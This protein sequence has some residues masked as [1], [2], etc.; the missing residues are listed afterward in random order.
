MRNK[1][2]QKFILSFYVMFSVLV[3][4]LLAGGIAVDPTRAQQTK[5]DQA[6]NGVPMIN[7]NAPDQRGLSHSYFSDYN[8]GK[9]GLILNNSNKEFERSQLGGTVYGNPNLVGRKEAETILTEVTGI[10]R[11]V[12]AGYTEILGKKADYILANPNGIYLNG[13]GFINTKNVTLTTGRPIKDA[14]GELK[15]YDVDDGTIVVGAQGVD[16]KNINKTEIIS[17]TAELNGA[18]YGGE[19]VNVVLGRN[20]YE[21]KSKK[22]TA[23]KENGKAKPKVA[24]DAKSLGSM[25]AGRVYLTSTEKGVGV[26]SQSSLYADTG[27]LTIDV[28]GDLVLK[29]AQAKGNASLKAQKVKVQEKLIAEKSV[30]V[31]GKDIVN[32][33]TIAANQNVSVKSQTIKNTGKIQGKNIA[34]E[35]EQK[36]ENSGVI[37]STEKTYITTENLANSGNLLGQNVAIENKETLVNTGLLAADQQVS[38]QS[39]TIEN[40]GNIE[41]NSIL[42]QNEAKLTNTGRLLA[43]ESIRLQDSDLENQGLIAANQITLENQN[44]ATNHGE[45]KAKDTLTLKSQDFIN[46]HKIQAATLVIENQ[47]DLINQGSILAKSAK[48]TTKK[49][50]N[51]GTLYGE[52]TLDIEAKTLVNATAGILAADQ[53]QVKSAVVNDGTILGKNLQIKGITLQNDG[54]ITAEATAVIEA[55]T[56]NTGTVQAKTKLA[57]TGDVDNSG[58]LKSEH[59]TSIVGVLHT[60]GYIYG[61]DV[62]ITGNTVNSSNILALTKL[63][64]TGNLTNH[65]RIGSGKSLTLSGIKFVNFDHISAEQLTITGEV[66]EN[67]GNITGLSGNFQIGAITNEETVYLKDDLSLKAT[68]I[69]NKKLIQ[70]MGNIEIQVS[71]T[72]TNQGDLFSGDTLSITAK[73]LTNSGRI[74]SEENSTYA[75]SNKITNQNL[76]QG[77]NLT[78]TT[79]DN[80]G[81]LTAVRDIQLT[82]LQNTGTVSA[83]ENFSAKNVDNKTASALLVTGNQVHVQNT[84]TNR[85]MISAKGTVSAAGVLNTGSILSDQSISLTGLSNA[86]GMIEGRSITIGNSGILDNTAG[87]IKAFE[88]DST[89]AITASNV[90]NT[91]GKIQSQAILTLKLSQDFSIVGTYTGNELFEIKAKSVTINQD[92]EN[93]GSIRLDLSGDL[94]IN[95]NSRFVTGADLTI[96][97]GRDVINTGILGSVGK[98]T[99]TITGKLNNLGTLNFGTGSHSFTIGN[100]FTNEGFVLSVGDLSLGSKNLI[101]QGQLAIAGNLTL[102]V[103]NTLT[104]DADTLL[105]AGN[106]MTIQAKNVINQRADLFSG[107]DLTINASGTVRNTVGT[108]ESL[109]KLKIVAGT[110]E[111]IGEMTGDYTVSKVPGSLL[112]DSIDLSGINLASIDQQLQN[113]MDGMTKRHSKS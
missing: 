43:D 112:P 64:I 48:I 103:G 102:T 46:D 29:D 50:Q 90:I 65:N 31:T 14:T 82:T 54:V 75:V 11:S 88:N 28:N 16:L 42:I 86:G 26:N 55:N 12:L 44:Q 33:G 96:L 22:V 15:A 52:A 24:L 100:D 62:A 21:P 17:R 74:S 4:P 18:I 70:S 30:A 47:K 27:D 81:N 58:N 95:N 36:I 41:G 5:V 94:L 67:K 77:K 84:L 9:E 13:A 89:I 73:D 85:G 80:S 108:I 40:Q 32:T 92:F 97:H 113:S 49:I 61:D 3:Q 7:I 91:G 63:A 19:E 2:I 109:G 87:S 72:L 71:Q 79:V 10:N 45:I 34:I 23:K 78:M 69:Q 98:F 25:Y 1:L 35:N 68:S 76:I 57:L 38:I 99:G 107:N 83:V 66:L 39:N 56:V 105:Y 93:A 37:A 101:N 6:I 60:A 111:N 20:E 106:N 59:T 51:D 104:N 8:V 110:I 53:L